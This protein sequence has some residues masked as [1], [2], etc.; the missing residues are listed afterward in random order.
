M[1]LIK[2]KMREFS[3][4]IIK[5]LG[6]PS[7][8]NLNTSAQLWAAYVS[9]P[10]NEELTMNDPFSR[11]PHIWPLVHQICLCEYSKAN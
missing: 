6:V 1:D 10:G 5:N 8:C 7:C 2:P 9:I 4:E 11:M 3:F